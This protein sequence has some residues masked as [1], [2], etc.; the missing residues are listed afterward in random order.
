ML[1]RT[2]LFLA[3]YV[4]SC[5]SAISNCEYE[6]DGFCEICKIDFGISWDGSKCL[7]NSKY[8][9]KCMIYESDDATCH[10]CVCG[11]G[12]TLP[13]NKCN[14]DMRTDA[15]EEKGC[16][17]FDKDK[18]CTFCRPGFTLTVKSVCIPETDVFAIRGCAVMSSNNRDCSLCH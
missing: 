6:V 13:A 11:Y 3:Y 5:S 12:L 1:L 15:I 14:I 17:T 4:I 10:T 18:K 2:V 16:S 7:D 9:D 8:V